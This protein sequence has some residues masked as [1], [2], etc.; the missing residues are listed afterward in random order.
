MH[1]QI[2]VTMAVRDLDKSQAFFSALGYTFDPTFS[3]QQAALMIIT[4]GS[5]SAMLMTEPFFSS[6]H[7]RQI[8]N[9]QE[10]VEMW[11]CLSCDS[12]AEVDDLVAKAVALG[13]TATGEPEDHGFMYGHGFTDLDGHAWQFTH[14]GGMPEG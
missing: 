14:M 3:N 4:E 6:F 11:V 9:T 10:A 1:K 5:I 2:I 7:S 8:T 13:A 12:R